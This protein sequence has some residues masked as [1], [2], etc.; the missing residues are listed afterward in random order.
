MATGWSVRRLSRPNS[1]EDV[2]WFEVVHPERLRSEL[3][4]LRLRLSAP[5]GQPLPYFTAMELDGAVSA[6]T[7][8][9]LPIRA[10]FRAVADALGGEGE[11]LDAPLTQAAQRGDLRERP[12][13]YR[14]AFSEQL[15]I[16]KEGRT[17]ADSFLSRVAVLYRLAQQLRPDA[18]VAYMQENVTVQPEDLGRIPERV[19]APTLRRWLRQAKARGLLP[20]YGSAPLYDR[21]GATSRR[22]LRVDSDQPLTAGFYH[23]VADAF[24]GAQRTGF[25]D[26][27]AEIAEA[28]EVT[29]AIVE[30]W[31]EE[32][33]ARGFL[34]APRPK[35]DES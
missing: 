6:E 14:N 7:L 9:G 20:E 30:E 26:P 17:L 1:G 12:R 25:P 24:L 34:E 18:P 2:A 27:A 10:L 21:S 31:L 23:H 19:P 22:G 4:G 33:R 3:R 35:E 29:R 11:D 8:R 32:A 15:E 28:S 5:A 13:P 16:Q